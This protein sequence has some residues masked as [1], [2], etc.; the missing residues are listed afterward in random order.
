MTDRLP[1]AVTRLA[2]VADPVPIRWRGRRLASGP[3]EISLSP[4]APSRGVLDYAARRARAE[5]HVR[6]AF[7]EL[8]RVLA[9]LGVDPALGAPVEA[10]LRAE[11][12]I[13]ED[14]GF[15]LGGACALRPH[16]L[17]GRG[18]RAAVL[19]GR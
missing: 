5:L 15:A 14:H 2:A 10:V 9:D 18:T 7:P 3:L 13:L 16:R 6:L 1:F 17:L 8:A 12:A 19:A 11:G 4:R